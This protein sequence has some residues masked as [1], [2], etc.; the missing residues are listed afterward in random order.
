MKYYCEK[1]KLF[2]QVA[3][4][5]MEKLWNLGLTA[6]PNEFGGLL[7]G[8]YNDTR[9]KAIVIDTILPTNF[10]SSRY[11]FERDS[12][13]LKEEL[14]NAYNQEPRLIYLGEWHTHPD[15]PAYPSNDDKNALRIIANHHEVQITNPILLIISIN[16]SNFSE[17]FFVLYKN[18]IIKYEKA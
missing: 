3:E 18:D 16:R 5:L 1:A 7:I 8:Y 15:L 10:K 4:N 14:L 9:D 13:G 6:Y 12:H 11:G 17:N 2:I